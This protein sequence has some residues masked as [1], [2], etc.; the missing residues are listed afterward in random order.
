ML[1]ISW[2]KLKGV[3]LLYND[4]HLIPFTNNEDSIITKPFETIVKQV[5]EKR[6]EYAKGTISNLMYKEIGN[7]IYGSVVR[8]MSNKRK[9]DIK[10]KTTQ[11][12]NGDDLSNPLIA[13]WTTAF[14]RSII[15]ECLHSIQNLHGVV[16]S[17]TTDGFI[18]DL[19]D[20][21]SKVCDNYLFS[22][23]KIIRQVLSSD[24]TG[25]EFKNSGKGILAW[26]TRGQLGFESKII[27]TTKFK[28]LNRMWDKRG[29][30]SSI[31]NRD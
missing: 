31:P 17:V 7:S 25:L 12:L 3:S 19:E 18:T 13:S 20:L 28:V 2:Q 26:T 1:N 27:A 11:R 14:I 5:Q 29:G 10:T 15:G 22:E 8:G 9:F 24:N 30:W 23:F 21:E 6:G 16:V 4:I